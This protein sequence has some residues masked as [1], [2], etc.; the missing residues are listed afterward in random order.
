MINHCYR[1]LMERATNIQQN[2]KTAE[3]FGG[4]NIFATLSSPQIFTYNKFTED[5]SGIKA[6]KPTLRGIYINNGKKVVI[7]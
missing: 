2:A 3:M 7:K 5:V 6:G 4:L 1:E